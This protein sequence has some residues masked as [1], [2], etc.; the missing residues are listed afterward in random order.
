MI[1][2]RS[3]AFAWYADAICKFMGHAV[4]IISLNNPVVQETN[5]DKKEKKFINMK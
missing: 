4:F 5:W 2:E 1:F 3:D